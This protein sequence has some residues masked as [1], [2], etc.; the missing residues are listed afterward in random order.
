MAIC[1]WPEIQM[2]NAGSDVVP[3]EIS[4]DSQWTIVLAHTT[5]ANTYVKLPDDCEIGDVVEVHT[6]SGAAIGIYP[7][8]GETLE[9]QAPYVETPR[10]LRKLTATLWGT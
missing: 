5:T 10:M 4:R 8:D 1:F 6:D 7:P 9:R 3:G 2:V